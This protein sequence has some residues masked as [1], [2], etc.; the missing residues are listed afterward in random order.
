MVKALAAGEREKEIAANEE[1]YTTHTTA[2]ANPS[3]INVKRILL[4]ACGA[5]EKALE[6]PTNGLFTA[7]FLEVWNHEAAAGPN[8]VFAFPDSYD[9][10]M[11]AV[12]DKFGISDEQHPQLA[13]EPAGPMG[14]TA[15]HPFS[16]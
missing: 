15:E 4:S 6:G 11:D 10:F 8:G 7:A 3:P 9:T 13:A 16:L 14:F 2:P 5:K 1:F 12:K